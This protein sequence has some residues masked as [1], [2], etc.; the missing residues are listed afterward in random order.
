MKQPPTLLAMGELAKEI[1]RDMGRGAWNG[2]EAFVDGCTAEELQ[3]LLSWLW[4]WDLTEGPSNSN[5]IGQWERKSYYHQPFDGVRSIPGKII[6]QVRK[7]HVADLNEDD[8][9]ELQ[10][11][12]EERAIGLAEEHPSEST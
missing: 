10:R 12:L 9:L 5:P 11:C 4:L 7:G 3:R 8:Q 6:T 1:I 2:H